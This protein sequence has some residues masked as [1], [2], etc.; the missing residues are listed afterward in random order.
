MDTIRDD[1]SYITPS[2]SERGGIQWISFNAS[3][4]KIPIDAMEKWR[5]NLYRDRQFESGILDAIDDRLKPEWY[6][7]KLHFRG[8]SP[9]SG[10]ESDIDPL[11]LLFA[12]DSV[13]L[14]MQESVISYD[15]DGHE[16]LAFS[17]YLLDSE[18]TD[19]II[20][21]SKRLDA[22]C[23]SAAGNSPF[24]KRGGAAGLGDMPTPVDESSITGI[25]GTEMSAWKAID[26][27]LLAVMDLCGF[28]S[29]ID[30]VSQD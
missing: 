24:Y 19:E 3:P 21:M 17:G 26:R 7:T 13:H 29:W 10:L 8:W 12:N 30:S 28:I 11:R 6:T 15:R 27:A 22:I 16:I 18:W 23:T 20:R 14:E 25:H 1:S 2:F 5:A 4:D 9:I